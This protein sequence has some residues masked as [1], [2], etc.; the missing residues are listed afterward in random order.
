MKIS[1]ACSYFLKI[2]HFSNIYPTSFKITDYE[3][4]IEKNNKT[5]KYFTKGFLKWVVRQNWN[6]F[7][8]CCSHFLWRKTC[9]AVYIAQVPFFFRW[10]RNYLFTIKDNEVID[11]KQYGTT[12]FHFQFDWLWSSSKWWFRW[13]KEK[14]KKEDLNG[15]RFG[16]LNS[17]KNVLLLQ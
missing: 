11:K 13:F 14:K 1:T 10:D 15:Y 8:F 7:D 12:R 9:M 5:K 17:L 16:K 6:L 2:N 3:A 4:Q